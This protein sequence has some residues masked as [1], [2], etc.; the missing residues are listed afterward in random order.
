MAYLNNRAAAN[1]IAHPTQAAPAIPKQ[2]TAACIGNKLTQLTAFIEDH[3]VNGGKLGVS[4]AVAATRI[5]YGYAQTTT[6][7]LSARLPEIQKHIEGLPT[8]MRAAIVTGGDAET[9]EILRAHIA[10]LS[11]DASLAAR[12]GA[13]WGVTGLAYAAL[14]L[15]V[16]AGYTLGATLGE[17]RANHMI[18][19]AMDNNADSQ[20]AALP[21]S[22]VDLAS[23]DG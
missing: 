9:R 23:I 7:A 18:M 19:E 2:S 8:A 17:E 10:G 22:E 21:P 20:A 5:A 14:P 16:S 15:T 6:D 4:F 11:Q 13:L 12:V 3:F 1:R